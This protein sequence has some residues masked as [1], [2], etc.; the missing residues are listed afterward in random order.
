VMVHLTNPLLSDS[1]GDQFSD[2][3]EIAAGTDPNDPDDFPTPAVPS[4]GPLGRLL[5]AALLL[6]AGLGVARRRPAGFDA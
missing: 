6:L 3:D 1:D 5:A 2:P 4:M